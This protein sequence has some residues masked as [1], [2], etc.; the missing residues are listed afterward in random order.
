MN[1][2]YYC[3]IWNRGLCVQQGDSFHVVPN[4]GRFATERIYAL[5]PYDNNRMLIGTRTQGLF[6]YDGKDFVPF[7]T[8]AD[9][10]IFNTSLYG[11]LV[12]SNGLIALNTFNDGMVIIDH[13]G[14]LIQRIDKSVGLQDNSVDNLFEDSRGNLWMPLFNGIAK[15]DLQ[16]AL[17]YYNE[18]QGLPAKTVFTIGFNNDF[19]YAGTNNGVFVLNKSTNRFEKVNGTSG[20]IGNFL[21]NGKDLL[22][23]GAEK[24]YSN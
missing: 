19:M 24:G 12:L 13:Q 23:A 11:G 7:K 6:I 10:Y 14:K 17:T 22:V 18:A 5:L 21:I 16:S 20:Q 3:R 1:G 2:K 9:P 8:E 4:G 15:I